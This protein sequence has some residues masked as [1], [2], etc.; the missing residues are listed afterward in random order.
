MPKPLLRR[1]PH[2]KNRSLGRLA[3]LLALAFFGSAP[4]FAQTT[5]VI[6]ISGFSFT[7][8]DITIQVGDS[9][10]WINLQAGFHNVVETDCPASTGS[11]YNGGYSS[12]A[13]G[14]V[15]TFTLQ[16]TA[17]GASCFVCEPHAFFGMYG[18]VTVAENSGSAYCFGDG[19]GAPCPCGASGSPGEGC[20]NTGGTGV[21]LVGTGNAS[22]SND[23]F[24]LNVSGI[25]GSKSGLCVKGSIQLGG[26]LGNPMGD[27]LL[28]T[29]PE[30]RSQVIMS[31]AGGN[32]AMSDW[33]GQSF[34]SFANVANSGAA[35]Y[36]QWWYRDPSNTCTGSGFNFTNGWTV[37]WQ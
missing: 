28:C 26:G 21:Q 23:S 16:F 15:D 14:A 12:G 33:R 8:Q 3:T 10:K 32:V 19:T 9:V 35:T 25:P 34:S 1:R 6:D 13:P 22:F 20:A 30:L 5:H 4:S 2:V 17:T 37:D 29:N 18:R 7:P 24:A 11:I 31:D 36:Y 27:G